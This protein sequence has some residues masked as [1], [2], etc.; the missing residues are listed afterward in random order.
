MSEQETNILVDSMVNAFTEIFDVLDKPYN[1]KIYHYTDINGL[2]GILSTKTIRFTNHSFLNDSHEIKYFYDLFN[3]AI[4]KRQYSFKN[5]ISS[6]DFND[7]D[8]YIASFTTDRNSLYHWNGYGK[9]DNAY[10]L[11]LNTK[12][13]IERFTRNRTALFM[14]N[15]VY[16]EQRQISLI[17]RFL[18][19]MDDV[20]KHTRDLKG[21]SREQQIIIDLKLIFELIAPV[22]KNPIFRMENE[23][24][25]FISEHYLNHLKRSNPRIL[26]VKHIRI[27]GD[28]FIPYYEFS[29]ENDITKIVEEIIIGPNRDLPLTSK[30]LSAFLQINNLDSIRI[31]EADISMNPI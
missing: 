21:I 17:E 10:S 7:T 26:P 14:G 4:G 31:T 6:H 11:T 27:R 24:R 30:G 18:E 2:N 25:L 15:V 22:I 13:L 1:D 9:F 16:D 20:Y 3:D 5:E 23:V 29:F 8:V 12:E 28:R 19:N